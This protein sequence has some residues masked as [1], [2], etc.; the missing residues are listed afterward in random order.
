MIGAALT[1]RLLT[2]SPTGCDTVRS[3]IRG[4]EAPAKSERAY[5]LV[6][7]KLLSIWEVLRYSCFDLKSGKYVYSPGTSIYGARPLST[8][9][10]SHEIVNPCFVQHKSVPVSTLQYITIT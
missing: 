8:F 1:N 4:W 5:E 7:P 2:K 6:H 10:N 9:T 3:L